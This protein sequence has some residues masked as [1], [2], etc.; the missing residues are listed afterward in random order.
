MLYQPKNCAKQK[1]CF[2]YVDVKCFFNVNKIEFNRAA[3]KYKFVCIQVD[4]K[5]LV[6]SSSSSAVASTSSTGTGVEIITTMIFAR[7]CV[8]ERDERDK[9]KKKNLT[10]QFFFVHKIC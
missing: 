10:Q 2:P 3:V 5:G 4:E 7:F 6:G 1:I 8:K 9:R